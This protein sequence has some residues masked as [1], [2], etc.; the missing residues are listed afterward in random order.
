MNI[1]FYTAYE[2]GKNNG[3]VSNVTD[4]W[5]HYFQKK[6][7]N[8][9]VAFLYNAINDIDDSLEQYKLPKKGTSVF[10]EKLLKEKEI[11]V[12]INQQGVNNRISIPCV[13]ACKNAGIKLISVIHNTP[14]ILLHSKYFK[15]FLKYKFSTAV[16]KKILGIIQKSSIYKGGKFIHDNSNYVSVLSP[17]YID[18]YCDLNVGYK[19]NKVVS[20]YNPLT[21]E[22]PV[23][24]KEKE[25]IVLFVGRLA[26]QKSLDKL[27]RIWH[28][29]ENKLPDWKLVIVGDGPDKKELSR[30]SVL[31]NN[32]N[33]EF[34]GHDNPHEYYR[35]SKIFAMTSVFE[36]LPMT[37]IECQTYGVV[38]ILFNSFSSAKDIV[39]H[40]ENGILIPSFD[41]G[42][43]ASMLLELVNN[44]E[45]NREMSKFAYDFVDKF[46]PD[47]LYEEWLSLMCD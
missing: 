46:N 3:G 31:L 41:E 4:F 18:E 28:L 33:V 10:F 13:I 12:V 1:L 17:S 30:M 38:P 7:H 43:Y 11:S 40:G 21:F 9:Y 8:V 44:Q 47:K 14:D 39:V 16:L 42:K 37:L 25:N 32:K 35:K 6:G 20:I 26:Y 22:K 15:P 36:G 34:V 24:N 2:V 29:V 45:K 23:L 5:Y 19:S 27:I